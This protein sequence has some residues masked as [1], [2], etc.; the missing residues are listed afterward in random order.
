MD[1]ICFKHKPKAKKN[2][3]ADY[4]WIDGVESGL[5]NEIVV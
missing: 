3:Q 5:Q 4:K 1:K 2:I